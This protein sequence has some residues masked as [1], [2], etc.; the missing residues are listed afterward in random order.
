MQAVTGSYFMLKGKVRLNLSANSPMFRR[1]DP[2]R[3]DTVSINS[4]KA[5]LRGYFAEM[6][7]YHFQYPKTF[8]F[9]ES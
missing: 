3:S 8:P 7:G 9:M 5:P 4:I 2:L 1:G 6:Y